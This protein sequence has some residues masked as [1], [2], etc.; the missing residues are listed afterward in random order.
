MTAT[1]DVTNQPPP[2]ADYDVFTS[3][4]ALREAVLRYDAG[5]AIA[6]AEQPRSGSPAASTR[7]A[8]AEE[9]NKYPPVLKTHD[10]LRPPNR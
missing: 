7:S 1:H 3:D 9:A 4:A 5:W 10:R 8:G 6:A 2:L